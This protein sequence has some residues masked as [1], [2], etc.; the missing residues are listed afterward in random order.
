VA[1]KW[2]GQAASVQAP[3]PQGLA[4][5]AVG[6][7]LEMLLRR[8]SDKAVSAGMAALGLEGGQQGLVTPGIWSGQR[9]R[10]RGALAPAGGTSW[11]FLC[12]RR[13]ERSLS[14]Q[15]I[16]C[17]ECTGCLRDILSSEPRWPRLGEQ[18]GTGLLPGGC[19]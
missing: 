12:F 10:P 11:E 3:P 18:E 15:G 6:N 9:S 19:L 5:E 17:S 1:W 8:E 2:K 16:V 14:R 4:W 7:F 13:E